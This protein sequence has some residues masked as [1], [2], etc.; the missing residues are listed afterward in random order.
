M[1]QCVKLS[2]IDQKLSCAESDNSG[3]IVAKVIFGY[4][5]E[6]AVFPDFPSPA[7]TAAEGL[8]LEDAGSLVGD[9][10]MKKGTCAFEFE[11]TQ[12]SGSLTIAPQ[13]DPG[14]ISFLYTLNLE[15]A[16]IRRK[17][18]GLMNA[19]K[20]R[21]MFFLAQDMNGEW[22]LLG[23]KR[24]G[25]MLNA[26]E[27]AQTGQQATDQ[28]KTALAFTYTSPRALIYTGDTEN[29]LTVQE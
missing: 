22:Y 10:V 17:V 29:V 23:D 2:S 4:H 16:R 28:N 24:R 18:L 26:G 1:T 19:S 8:S 13:G 9:L 21:K 14:N 5:D 15:A 11:Y 3:G 20:S 12:D 6:V 7:E 25:A 27:G